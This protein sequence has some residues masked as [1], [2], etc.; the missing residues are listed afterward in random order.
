M[1]LYPLLLVL[2]MEFLGAS[3]YVTKERYSHLT[4][5]REREKVHKEGKMQYSIEKFLSKKFFQVIG[6][7]LFNSSIVIT[8]NGKRKKTCFLCF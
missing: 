4:A 5:Q 8:T 7:P 3:L 1:I 2:G 6:L